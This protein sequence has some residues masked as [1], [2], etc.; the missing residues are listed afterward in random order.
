M[1]TGVTTAGRRQV[2][3]DKRHAL[4][5]MARSLLVAGGIVVGYFVLPM[6]RFDGES[7]LRLVAG[8][9]LVAALLAW[10]IR[11]ITRSPYPRLRAVETLAVTLSLFFALFATAYYVMSVA[12]PANFNE[13]LTRLDAAYF[14]VTV[15][16]TVGFGD[17]VA[18]TQ[19]ARAV[20]TAQMLGDLVLVGLVAHAVVNAVRIGMERKEQRP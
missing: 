4:V 2:P 7:L 13:P 14:T 18:T 9:A 8:L 20:A 16:A 19:T 3:A 11:E 1:R 10:Q 6:T 15:F 17:I 12:D 5:A